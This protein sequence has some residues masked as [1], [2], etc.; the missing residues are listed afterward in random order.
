MIYT[1]NGIDVSNIQFTD[2]NGTNYPY[3]WCQLVDD[4]ILI[5]IGIIILTEIY[6]ILTVNQYYDG[7]YIDD[8]IALTRTYNI[9]TN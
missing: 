9:Q 1:Y 8:Y 3:N 2:N 6:P 7:T 5:G 4:D